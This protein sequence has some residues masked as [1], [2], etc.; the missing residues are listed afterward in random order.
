MFFTLLIVTFV[1]ALGVSALV[2]QMFDKPI[3]Q[4][5][6]RIIGDEISAGWQKYV[7]FALYVVGISGG[8]SLWRL[9]QYISGDTPL[10]MTSEQWVLEIYRVILDTLQS[11]AWVLLIFF[12]FALLAY[13][14]VRLGELRR[15]TTNTNNPPDSA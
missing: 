4:I 7:R 8:V 12:A 15:G 13:V 3:G 2:A 1:I 14:I 9:E 10:A 5:L 11:L 6:A